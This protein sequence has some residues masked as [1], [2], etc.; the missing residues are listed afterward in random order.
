MRQQ[1]TMDE[2]P[3]DLA[4][5]LDQPQPAAQCGVCAALARQRAAAEAAGDWSKV[6][7]YNIEIRDHPPHRRRPRP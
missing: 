1:T 7:D 5:P 6:S 3:I 4:L 2:Q